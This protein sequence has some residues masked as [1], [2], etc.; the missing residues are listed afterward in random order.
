M[1]IHYKG[2]FIYIKEGYKTTIL[3][4][5]TISSIDINRRK[6]TIQI[7]TSFKA[8]EFKFQNY[9]N[10]TM[11]NHF[12]SFLQILHQ[13]LGLDAHFLNGDVE[14][15]EEDEITNEVSSD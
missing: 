6:Y 11:I 10:Q 15:T 2:N 9:Y 13:A 1:V 12:Y 14:V 5:N 8:Y 7:Q 4:I 3:N